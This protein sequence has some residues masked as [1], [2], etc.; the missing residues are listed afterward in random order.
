LGERVRVLLIGPPGSGKGTQAVRI[1]EHFGIE[2]ISSGELLRREVARGSA[3]GQTVSGLMARGDLVPDG[4]VMDVLRKPVEAA[5]RAGG[6]VLD[7]F[8]RTVAQAEAAYLIALD[9]NAWVQVALSLEVP[10]EQLIERTLA[11]G[12]SS[13]RADDN[14]EVITHRLDVFDQLTPP[15]LAYYAQREILL[16]VDGAQSV[17]DVAAAAISSLE[18]VR[19]GLS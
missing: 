14:L 19:P 5:S 11:R 4:V 12:R 8:P 6:Y 15:L 13:G 16:K 17:D 3:I 9:I 10:R 2:H 7:G 18:R 1:A